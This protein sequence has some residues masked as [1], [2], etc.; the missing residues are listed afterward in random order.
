MGSDADGRY[1]YTD[2]NAELYGSLG[3]EGTTYQIGFDGVAKLLGDITGKTFLDFGCGTGRSARFLK[4]RGARHVYAVDHD[5]NMIDQAQS[6]ELD[7]VTFLRIDGAIPLPDAS[8]DGAVS[9]NVFIEI[10][11][12][13]AMTR[14]C[15]EIARTLRPGAPFVLESSSPMAFGRTFRNF[16]Y[17]HAGP[18]RSGETTPC[19]VTTPGGQFVIEDT[20]CTEDDY[21]GAVEQ[22]GLAVITIGY[23]RPRDPA[24]WSTDEATIPPCIVIEARK[25]RRD[26]VT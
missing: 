25:R 5:Q 8:M 9:L 13:G 26:Q 18:L 21:V 19:I 11:T 12:L 20:S 2:G 22:A 10:R 24:A 4:E 23:P 17:P 14:A 15:A 3:I 1:R 6:R 16:S 7:G